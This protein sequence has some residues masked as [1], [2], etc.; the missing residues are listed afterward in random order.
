M[1][2]KIIVLML[3]ACL[4]GKVFAQGTPVIDITAILAFLESLEEMYKQY[5][6]TVNHLQTSYSQLQQTLKSFEKPDFSQLN[7]KDPLGSWGKIMSYGNTQMN[8]VRDVENIMNAK[9]MKVG[10]Y[11][12][13]IA[14]FF[15]HPVEASRSAVSGAVEFVLFDPF[16]E[17]SVAEKAAFHA[18]YGM[19]PANYM[20]YHKM[21]SAVNEKLAKIESVVQYEILS[22]ESENKEIE[23]IVGDGADSESMLTQAQVDKA[24]LLKQIAIQ[25]KTREV[26]LDFAD[27]WMLAHKQLELK[28][29][30]EQRERDMSGHEYSEGF[31]NAINSIDASRFQGVKFD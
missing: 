20:R 2:K 14:D 1:R 31:V 24:L 28:N 26:L 23:T 11:S 27:S 10:N 18:K 21:G 7:A 19:S 8:K 29:E 22:D 3:L 9:S 30:E 25:A 6:A 4:G 12:Y 13:S 15:D 17:R 16:Q 5:E